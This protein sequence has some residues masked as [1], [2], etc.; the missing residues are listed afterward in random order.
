MSHSI[1]SVIR[2]QILYIAPILTVSTKP[3]RSD[4]EIS[5]GLLRECRKINV[6]VAFRNDVGDP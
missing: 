2:N 4:E 1:V 6:K 5:N 3:R